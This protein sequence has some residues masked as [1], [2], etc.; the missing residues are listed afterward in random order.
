M[1]TLEQALDWD[2]D[3]ETDQ[4]GAKIARNLGGLVHYLGDY[5]IAD[6]SIKQM[7]KQASVD[8]DNNPDGPDWTS[9]ALEA[10]IDSM[11]QTARQEAEE[12]VEQFAAEVNPEL[13]ILTGMIPATIVNPTQVL[14]VFFDAGWRSNGGYGAFWEAFG[15]KVDYDSGIRNLLFR[16]EGFGL[17]R[18]TISR[19]A[20]V[21]A[22]SQPTRPT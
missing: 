14:R 13:V 3:P 11:I 4:G 21:T 1:T 18:D 22:V 17:T 7:L 8:G 9:P 10:I 2:W 20:V 16:M 19:M 15:V 12:L 6:E 5:G